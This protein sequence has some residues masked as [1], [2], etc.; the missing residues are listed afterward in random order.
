M[1]HISLQCPAGS[2]GGDLLIQVCHNGYKVYTSMATS[3]EHQ[4]CYALLWNSAAHQNHIAEVALSIVW[5]Q[6]LWNS[7][8]NK[9]LH[10]QYV[11]Q[12]SSI[13]IVVKVPNC[14]NHCQYWVLYMSQ[15]IDVQLDSD[16]DWNRL[17]P[18][19]DWPSWSCKGTA[20][21]PL[22]PTRINFQLGLG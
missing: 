21:M 9:E 10:R 14:L 18:S 12:T 7:G 19:S 2:Q 4:H 11:E 17:S 6:G 8:A 1:R 3:R 13:K 16:S 22:L 15:G 20:P 5:P